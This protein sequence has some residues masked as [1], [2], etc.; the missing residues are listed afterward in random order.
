MSI[1]IIGFSGSLRKASYTTK[2]LEGFQALAPDSVEMDIARVDDLP[3]LNQ[4]LEEQL[5]ASV[6]KLHDTISSADAFIF[7]TP[8]YN[9][10]YSPVIKNLIDWGSRPQGNNKWDKK[11]A[12][13]IGCSPYS[14]GGFGA[15]HHLRQVLLYV[16]TYTLQQP[17]FYLSEAAGKMDEHGH[18]TD[19][20]TQKMIRD[21][22]SVYLGWIG[23]FRK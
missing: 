20:T 12:A 17:E 15:V 3:M 1:K 4:D 10:S 13:V 9:R 21:F 22:W 2:L 8:E 14:L 11:P 6:K 19:T 5:P 7:G 18:I 16:N 23:H